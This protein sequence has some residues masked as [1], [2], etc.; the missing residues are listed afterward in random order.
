MVAS[1]TTQPN[2]AADFWDSV[3]T[4]TGSEAEA[5]RQTMAKFGPPK[6]PTG[7]ATADS[8]MANP[9]MPR[10]EGVESGSS[11]AA[12]PQPI[13][14]GG[15][16]AANAAY[17]DPPGWTP[18]PTNPQQGSMPVGEALGAAGQQ[19][20]NTLGMGV[21]GAMGATDPDALAQLQQSDPAL[22]FL[23]KA[24]GTVMQG[25]GVGKAAVG[26][27]KGLAR[28]TGMSAKAANRIAT[29]A[30]TGGTGATL[31]A[32]GAEP[33]R[34]NEGAFWG[35]VFGLGTAAGVE[36]AHGLRALV[37]MVPKSHQQQVTDL[38]VLNQLERSNQSVADALATVDDILKIAPTKGVTVLEAMGPTAGSRALSNIPASSDAMA[39]SVTAQADEFLASVST[40]SR[41]RAINIMVKDMRL[42]PAYAKQVADIGDVVH[43]GR[44]ALAKSLIDLADR[45]PAKALQVFQQIASGRAVGSTLTKAASFVMGP[46]AKQ[47]ATAQA[48]NTVETLLSQNPVQYFGS[49]MGSVKDQANREAMNTAMRGWLSSFVG[50]KKGADAM[51]G[52]SPGTVYT[53]D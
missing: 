25:A 6:S 51:L 16:M 52:S 49:L 3:Y 38:L 29:I 14:V 19:F 30:T 42:S 13:P 46:L 24:G 23:A 37:N 40:W 53:K 12:I 33:G 34:R 2:K 18:D 10:M 20:L 11:S 26:I 48:E 39:K 22:S 44:K 1:T 9:G 32:A 35:T 43:E 47:A 7:K 5:T 4:K 50:G 36:L 17:P 27:A 8:I 21:P 15:A 31:G 45:E 28:W 41:K